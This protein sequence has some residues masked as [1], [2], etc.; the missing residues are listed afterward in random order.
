MI[1]K[2][3]LHRFA[4]L[5]GIR[6]DQAERDYIIVWNILKPLMRTVPECEVVWK[7]W[8]LK[9]SDIFSKF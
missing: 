6:F 7:D 2:G 4:S 1:T 9:F 8:N 3:E 5:E